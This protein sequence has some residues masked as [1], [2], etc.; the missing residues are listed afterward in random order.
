MLRDMTG[1]ANDH[2]SHFLHLFPESWIYLDNVAVFSDG[3]LLGQGCMSGHL[4]AL[5]SGPASQYPELSY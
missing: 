1:E 4:A 3:L 2:P 5:D